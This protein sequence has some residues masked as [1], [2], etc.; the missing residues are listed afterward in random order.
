M[1]WMVRGAV[2][3]GELWGG[4]RLRGALDRLKRHSAWTGAQ[5]RTT[6]TAPHLINSDVVDSG[7]P[8]RDTPHL[9]NR[10]VRQIG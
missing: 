4:D 10:Y 2:G 9:L 8:L 3:S 6:A 7:S 5:H 1:V